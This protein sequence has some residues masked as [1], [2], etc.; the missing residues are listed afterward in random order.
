MAVL[1]EIEYPGVTAVQYEE[2]S[3]L[4]GLGDED[5]PAGLLVHVAAIDNA[6]LRVVDVW[7]SAEALDAFSE[8]LFPAV[9]QAGFPEPSGPP[10]VT[11][12]YNLM[13]G[14]ARA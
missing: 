6:R 3:R 13:L 7:E 4:A 14:R 1:F 11:Q 5:R 8:I 12:V 10:K 2:A 9:K